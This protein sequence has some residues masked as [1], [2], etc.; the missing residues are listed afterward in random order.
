MSTRTLF[1][2]LQFHDVPR[3]V[4]FLEAVGFTQAAMHTDPEYPD[5]VVHAQFDWRDTGGVMFGSAKRPGFERPGWVDSA[6]HGQCYCVVESD[7]DVDRVY[8]AALAAGG[9]SVRPPESPDYGGRSCTVADPEGN[10]WS[11]G[12]YAGE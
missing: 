12:S 7:D 4:A 11:F 8:D 6:G 2:S 9:S 10:Q 5:V 3:A 1:H